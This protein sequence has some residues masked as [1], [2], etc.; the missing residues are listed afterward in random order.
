MAR[1]EAKRIS[2]NTGPSMSAVHALFSY[3][4]VHTFAHAITVLINAGENFSAANSNRV[5]APKL[6]FA[7]R[8]TVSFTGATG[9]ISFSNENNNRQTQYMDIVNIHANGPVNV[10]KN[11]GRSAKVLGKFTISIDSVAVWHSGLTSVP[12]YQGCPIGSQVQTTLKECVECPEN[13]YNDMINSTC[14]LCPLNSVT[15]K[16]EG[17]T[18]SKDCL[19]S[20]GYYHPNGSQYD[21]TAPCLVC[22]FGAECTGRFDVP[23]CLNPVLWE[24]LEDGNYVQPDTGEVVSAAYLPD[25]ARIVNGTSKSVILP[26][27]TG[28]YIDYTPG[29][30]AFVLQ[31][32]PSGSVCRGGGNCSCQTGHHGIKCDSCIELWFKETSGQCSRCPEGNWL[33]FRV[34]GYIILVCCAIYWAMLRLAKYK[35]GTT[36][37]AFC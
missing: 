17:S 35:K 22:P 23:Q 15:F 3:D 16:K 8:N 13:T 32:T 25:G 28:T 31:C 33:A 24:T 34:Y 7:L 2:L 20:V 1:I 6:M 26:G 9:P 29:A 18:S 12:V 30:P 10:H 27:W 14:S 4:V 5:L 11:I 19:C 36:N 37:I 21:G